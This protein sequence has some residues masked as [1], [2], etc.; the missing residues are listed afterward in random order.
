MNQ[1]D[2][3]LKTSIPPITDINMSDFIRQKSLTK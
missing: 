1:N 3:S 2:K